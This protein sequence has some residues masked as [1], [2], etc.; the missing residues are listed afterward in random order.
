MKEMGTCHICGR[1]STQSCRMCGLITCEKHL[2]DGVCS[3][4]RQ[5]SFMEKEEREN[6]GPYG[7]D[8]D[9]VYS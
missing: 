8:E 5:G 4:C 1:P 6:K 7:L 3:E 2:K 9:D